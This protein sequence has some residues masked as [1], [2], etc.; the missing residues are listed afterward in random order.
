MRPHA[1][2]YLS[3]AHGTTATLCGSECRQYLAQTGA[4]TA[5]WAHT[6]TKNVR[7]GYTLASNWR[8]FYSCNPPPPPPP[9]L[10]SSHFLSSFNTSV[11]P[12]LCLDTLLLR[13]R[14]SPPLLL[15][16][17]PFFSSL[18]PQVLQQLQYAP[19]KQPFSNRCC[20]SYSMP[21]LSSSSQI[22]VA[23]A[24]VCPT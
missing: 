11:S 20:N 13:C 2:C 19:P 16:F 15:F 6:N 24:T 1:R 18:M 12:S 3:L 21:H 5:Q 7:P 10:S 4:E 22:D 14:S 9:K 17:L 23:T 8:S